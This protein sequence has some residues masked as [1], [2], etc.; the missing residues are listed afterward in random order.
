MDI[1]QGQGHRRSNSA[2]F[3]QILKEIDEG[4]T[5]DEIDEVIAEVSEAGP[6]TSPSLEY[7]Y[8]RLTLT[9]LLQSTS[10]NL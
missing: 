7:K 8:F 6:L 3:Q 1:S 5:D 4:F 9:N 10:M 2:N